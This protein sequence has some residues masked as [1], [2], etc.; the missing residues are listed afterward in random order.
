MPGPLPPHADNLSHVGN[1]QIGE[2]LIVDLI[3][4][5]PRLAFTDTG[6]V[7]EILL[8]FLILAHIEGLALQ[9]GVCPLNYRRENRI[10]RSQNNR[11]ENIM[12]NPMAKGRNSGNTST[13]SA[14]ARAFH[15]RYA[16]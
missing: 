15:T 13:G 14:L 4:D 16:T 7:F 6:F 9:Y 10:D 12:H 11:W 1:T 3:I 5:Q 8:L 2:L